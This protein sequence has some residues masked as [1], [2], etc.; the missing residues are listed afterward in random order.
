MGSKEDIR[1][2]YD[3]KETGLVLLEIGSVLMSSGANTNRIRTNIN[4]ISSAYGYNTE[5]LVTHRAI[6]LSVSDNDQNNFFSSLKRTSPHGVNFKVISG[7]SRM[8]WKVVEENWNVEQIRAELDR[9]ASLPHYPRILVL[10]L[11][12]L[13]GASLCRIFGGQ[14]VEMLI[15]FTA[16]FSGLF[17]RQEAIKRNFNPYLCVYF[18]SLTASLLSGLAVKI[19]FGTMP[20]TAFATSVLFLVPGVPLINTFIDLL[21]GNL[22]NGILRGINGLIIAFSIALGLLTSMIIYQIW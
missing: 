11:V 7:I 19:H 9:L 15:A 14:F 4:R 5:L 6:M 3:L 18:G 20:E 21:D 17:V 8:S 22:M 10:L 2:T 13:A 12:A 1:E 16:T